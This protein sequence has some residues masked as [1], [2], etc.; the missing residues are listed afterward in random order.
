MTAVFA[1]TFYWIALADFFDTSHSRALAVTASYASL[2]VVTT[3]EV[4]TEYLNYFGD[5]P[6][7][8]RQKAAESVH[9]ILSS[10]AFR[11]VSQSRSSFLAG[12]ELY[13]AR[14]DKGYSLT[15]CIS[16]ATMRREGLTE[17]LTED[18]HFE[19]EGFRALFR[20]PGT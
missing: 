18:R 15:D 8:V 16:M 3:D 7:V 17:V 13:A 19:Q 12:L 5:R 9:R 2:Y 14:L 6:E 20:D 4:L 11:V 1:D 10:R